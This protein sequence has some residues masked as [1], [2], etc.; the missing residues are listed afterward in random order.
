MCRLACI[1]APAGPLVFFLWW[2]PFFVFFFPSRKR[3]GRRVVAKAAEAQS[4]SAQA[5]LTIGAGH[6][7]KRGHPPK[8]TMSK[9]KGP[10]P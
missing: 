2:S 4:A 5:G 6:C 1:P 3:V 8:D 7:T 9:K 10:M